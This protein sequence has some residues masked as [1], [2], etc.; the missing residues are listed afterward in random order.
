M[1]PKTTCSFGTIDY[2][3]YG[4]FHIDPPFSHMWVWGLNGLLIGC[5]LLSVWHRSRSLSWARGADAAVNPTEALA[6]GSRFVCG[7]VEYAAG[8][9]NAI[10][11]HVNQVGTETKTK[12]DWSHKWEETSRTTNAEPFYVRRPNGERVRIQPGDDPLLVDKPDEMKQHSQNSRTRIARLTPGEE[13]IVRGSLNRGVD[14]EAQKA[15]DYRSSGQG[16]VMTPI[17]AD[18]MEVSTEKLGERHRKRARAF[19]S[20]IAALFWIGLFMNLFFLFYHFRLFEGIETCARL[21]KKNISTSVDSKG[22]RT[23]HYD[24]YVEVDA[25]G[26]PQLDNELDDDDWEIVEPGMILGY[27]YL[28]YHPSKSMPGTD[29]SLNFAAILFAG[30]TAAIGLIVYTSTRDYKRWYEGKME[31]RGSGRLPDYPPIT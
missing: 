27:R 16:W 17:R 1:S 21:T 18:R 8:Q 5:A 19:G 10:T 9:T 24:I 14:P 3:F 31:D 30:F 22:R 13:V 23:L 2:N 6:P 26:R 7:K 25:P 11:V 4:D 20:T 28:P 12:N 15:S 29:T